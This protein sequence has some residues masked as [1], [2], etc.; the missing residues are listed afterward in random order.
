M[1]NTIT[2]GDCLKVM[3]LIPDKS[4]DLILCDLPYGTTGCKWDT[5]IP[6]DDLWY[7]YNRISDAF[8]LFASAPF[9]FILGHSNI[10]N[11]KYSLVW[12]KKQTGNPFLATKQP[13]KIHE[14]IL[15][16][17][18]PMYNPQMVEGKMRKKGGGNKSLIFGNTEEKTNDQ[19]YPTS[20][21]EFNNCSNRSGRFHPTQKPI[22]LFEYLIRTYT[23]E[24]DIILDNCIGSGTTAIACI[25]TGRNY[26]GIEK[27]EKYCQ[28]AKTRIRELAQIAG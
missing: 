15:V 22:A 10:S 26:I 5:I 23:N 1:I 4:V 8:I 27:E 21:L 20:I 19:Y 13:L 11:L 24:G 16:F 18:T 6:L 2:C 25:N 12:N 14:D 28:I 9:T 3:P 17:G 7:E